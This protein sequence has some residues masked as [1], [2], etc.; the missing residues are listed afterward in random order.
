MSLPGSVTL[1][2]G[3]EEVRFATDVALAVLLALPLAVLLALPLVCALE[4]ELL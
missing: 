4:V 1:A 2:V 3:R